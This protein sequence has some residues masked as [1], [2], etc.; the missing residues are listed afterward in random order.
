MARRTRMVPGAPNDRAP[1][2]RTPDRCFIPLIT[3]LALLVTLVT[4]G[5]AHAREDGAPATALGRGDAVRASAVGTSG[6]YF[7]PAGMG[8]IHQ[9]QFEAGYG[10]QEP[11]DGHTFNAAAVDSRTNN[12]VAMG[13]AYGFINS[14]ASGGERD[15]HRIRGALATGHRWQSFG[16][17]VGVGVHYL[18]LDNGI[19]EDGEVKF[20]TLDAGMIF[21][22][23]QMLRIGVVG[24]NLIDTKSLGEAPR[25]VGLGVSAVF[26]TVEFS[27]DTDL[28]VQSD[29]DGDVLPT[30][31]LGAQAMLGESVVA[32]AGYNMEG[33]TDAKRITA[34][35]GYVSPVLAADA[36]MGKRLDDADGWLVSVAFRYFLP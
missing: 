8:L 13:V 6:L 31:H 29:P 30:Y 1:A 2:V 25:K 34:G 10:W 5:A 16:F 26:D 17:Q 20:L 24:Q 23:A 22:I 33:E 36:S 19:A 3:A 27:F 18:T 4:A 32:R 28:D 7:N 14:E 9:Y 35:L 12:A 15:G 11:R 21:E